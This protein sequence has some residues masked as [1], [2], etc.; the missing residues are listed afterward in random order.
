MKPGRTCGP[1]ANVIRITRAMNGIHRAR[2][3]RGCVIKITALIDCFLYTCRP[4]KGNGLLATQEVAMQ[5]NFETIELSLDHLASVSGGRDGG[6]DGGRGRDGGTTTT[7]IS[8]QNCT[9]HTSSS[10][11][12]GG[13]E[14]TVSCTG[15]QVIK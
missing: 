12:D 3:Q 11:R 9:T 14:V 4:A 8:G 7:T 5:K 13:T 2:D 10:G 6:R 1:G 15:P